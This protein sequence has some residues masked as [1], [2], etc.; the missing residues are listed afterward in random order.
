MLKKTP[1]LIIGLIAAAV[2]LSLVLTS[3]RGTAAINNKKDKALRL[4]ETSGHAART[5]EAF[6]HWNGDNPPQ[7]SA[8]CAKCHSTP[9]FKDF[10]G[11]DGSAVGVVNSAAAIGTTVECEVCHIDRDSGILRNWTSVTFPSGVTVNNLGPEAL[12]MECHQGRASKATVDTKIASAGVANDDTSSTK[13]TFSNVHYY[14]AAASQFGTFVKGGYEYADHEYDA[15]FSHIT[16][17]N[18][19]ITCHNPHSLKVNLRACNT[20]HTGIA[21]PK[22]IRYVGSQVDYDGDGDITEGMYYEIQDIMAKALD[23]IMRYAR[24]VLNK[25]IVYDPVNNPYWFLDANGNGTKDADET[26]GYDAFSVR[27][28][29]AAYNYQVATKDPNNFAHNGKYIIELLYDSMED[30]NKSL[31]VPTDLA[32]LRR[33]DEGHFNGGSMPY[34]D[35]DDSATYTVSSSCARCHS[36]TGLKNYLTTGV[37]Q[38]EPVAN[39]ML[40]TTCHTEPPELFPAP[41]ITF[42][43][44]LTANL[45]TDGSNLCMVCHQGRSSKVNVDTT[46]NANPNSTNLSFAN[47]HY[48][49][50]AAI[51]LGTEVKGGYEFA[52]KTYV[53]RQP[54]SN[55][56]G[57]FNTCVQCHMSAAVTAE[58]HNWTM[59]AHNVAEPMKENCVPCHGQDVSQPF[60]GSD[61]ERFDFEKIRPGNIPDYDADGNTTESLKDEIAGLQAPLY[62]QIQIYAL[63]KFPTGIL[64]GDS[65]PY[66]FKDSNGNGVLDPSEAT[67]TNA[68]KFDAKLLRASYNY[69]TSLKDPHGFIHNARYIAQLLVDSIEHIG[70]NISAYVWR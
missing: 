19:C 56:G 7:V 35:W 44:G 22:D 57:R 29:K 14:A 54:F 4:W 6:V 16:G 23:T 10:V 48:F 61:P 52:G 24:T 55:H 68:F 1:V 65:N 66:W 11:A 13:L 58:E 47:I 63:S 21:D 27:L 28:L 59:R 8:S 39:G 9:G 69:H 42:P 64:Y 46:I 34:R 51:F 5:D 12:C 20:C 50:A 37:Q 25:P 60:K 49:P 62:A 26:T 18:A 70:G 33:N 31:A 2:F 53:G 41:V 45:A 43:S 38:A 3:S 30:L 17:Y 36:A 67:S 15:R 40:C 32:L